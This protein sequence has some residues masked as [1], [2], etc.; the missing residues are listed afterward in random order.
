MDHGSLQ[1]LA[2]GAALDDLDPVERAELD[3]HLASCASCTALSAELDAV[4][5]D[6]ALAAP[7]LRPPATLKGEVLSAL[8]GPAVVAT[9]QPAP[10]RRR[11]WRQGPTGR[12]PRRAQS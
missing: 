9:E 10:V 4:L 11:P 1:Q 8:R 12:S 3:A 6:L 7:A 5:A 2:A